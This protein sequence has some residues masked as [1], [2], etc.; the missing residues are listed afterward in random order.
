MT[1]SIQEGEILIAKN[2]R[3]GFLEQKGV[4][5]STCTVKDEVTSRM[6]RL[7]AATENLKTVEEAVSNGDTS[8]DMLQKLSEATVEFEAAGGYDLEK[9]IAN[10]LNGLGFVED[11]WDRLCSEFSGG[12]QMRIAL[13]R[14]LLSEPGLL[15]LDEPTVISCIMIDLFEYMNNCALNQNHLDKGAKEWLGNYLSK[16]D[17]TLL[18]VSH[19][20]GLLKSA[21]NSI[22]EIKNGKMELYKSR[23]YDQWAIEREERVKAAL[24]EY[25][26]NQREIARLQ[27]FVD[28][29]GAKTVSE[30]FRFRLVHIIIPELHIYRWVLHL[31]KVK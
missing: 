29:F 9:K 10:V 1:L 17:G 5:G 16:Y 7:V 22:A 14:L 3:I 26:A 28:R 30:S 18:V 12:W 13:A 25:E 11:D 21:V 23:S 19:D 8:D 6:D 20:E 27:T 24:A 15:I 4:S 2:S 31:R